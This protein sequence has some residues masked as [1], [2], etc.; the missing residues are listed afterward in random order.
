VKS[1]NQITG[2]GVATLLHPRPV[3]LVT[4][5]D[6]DGRVDVSTVAWVTPLSHT[7]PLVGLSVRPSSR[8]CALIDGNGQFVVNVVDSSMLSAIKTCGNV[9]GFA[10][11]KIALAGLEAGEASVIAP[12]KLSGALAWLECDVTKRVDVGDHV[13]FIA[14]VLWAQA[15]E[16]VF[17]G[18][19]N[20]DSASVLQCF[21][22]DEFGE[23]AGLVSEGTS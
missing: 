9:S 7:P 12:P 22:H 14:S 23:C 1:Q 2:R 4:T 11:D 5:C 3:Y 8:T 13:L 10:A 17:D 19:W 15:K 16:G 6:E 21:A 20:Q 18:G